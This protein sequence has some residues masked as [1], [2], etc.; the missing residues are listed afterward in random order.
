MLHFTSHEELVV[1]ADNNT[2]HF[3]SLDLSFM[4]FENKESTEKLLTAHIHFKRAILRAMNVLS[5]TAILPWVVA[6]NRR[7]VKHAINLHVVPV[8]LKRQ[9]QHDKKSSI[10]FLSLSSQL[11][12]ALLSER[13]TFYYTWKTYVPNVLF[14]SKE[15]N[16]SKSAWK[17]APLVYIQN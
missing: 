15:I 14:H 4:N 9:W 11:F 7:N 5:I 12:C 17:Y 13:S 1:T 10:L 6:P 2:T 8:S 16:P 3:F